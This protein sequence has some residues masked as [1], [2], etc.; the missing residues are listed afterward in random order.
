MGGENHISDETWTEIYKILD[1]V[2]DEC[3]EEE[4][5]NGDILKFEGW[6]PNCFP[7]AVED[8]D[9]SENYARSQSPDIIEKDWLPQMKRRRCRLITSGFEPGGLYGVTWALFRRIS[10]IQTEGAKKF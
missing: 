7:E 10:R 5:S 9:D 6:S 8:E 2:S 4:L 3:N 1:R